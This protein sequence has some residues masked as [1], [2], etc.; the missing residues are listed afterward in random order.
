MKYN[1]PMAENTINLFPHQVAGHG[2]LQSWDEKTVLKPCTK[3]EYDFYRV[4]FER[5]HELK[6]WIPHLHQLIEKNEGN[7]RVNNFSLGKYKHAVIIENLCYGMTRPCILDIKIGRQ[8][9]A[10]DAS[11]DKK[12]RLD[13][14]S[15]STTSGSHGFRITGMTCWDQTTSSMAHYSTLWG[16]TL[17]PD[18]IVPS[19]SLFTK[20]LPANQASIV[21]DLITSSLMKLYEELKDAHIT[22]R[23]SSILITY[24]ACDSFLDGFEKCNY[25][26]RLIDFAHSAFSTEVDYNYLFGLENLIKCFHE[27]GETVSK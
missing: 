11:D 8:L 26:L 19:L 24:D 7:D 23:S 22:F 5:K 16:K 27:L 25:N 3:T 10:E 15:S 12:R 4:V 20:A 9:W 6:N 13:L 2:N 18:L 21:M 17:T 1:V 14:V